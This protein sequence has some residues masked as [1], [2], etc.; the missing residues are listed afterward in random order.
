MATYFNFLR[1]LHGYK[2]E[3]TYSTSFNWIKVYILKN[4]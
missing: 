4:Y 2:Y 1:K 3:L